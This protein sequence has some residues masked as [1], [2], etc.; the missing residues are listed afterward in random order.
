MP[1]NEEIATSGAVG[2]CACRLASQFLAAIAT[3]FAAFSNPPQL[4]DALLLGLDEPV[5]QCAVRLDFQGRIEGVGVNPE[6]PPLSWEAW[7][8]DGWTEC[9]VSL[10]ETGGFNRAG[11]V[12]IHVP[13]GHSASVIEGDRAGWVRA[14]IIEPA[15]G[16]PPYTA[17]PIVDRLAACTV[18]GTADA[19]HADI[20]A[21][22]VLGDSEGVPGQQLP[23]SKAPILAGS[24]APL[25]ETSSDAGWQEWT[26]VE[27]FAQSTATD[28]HFILDAVSGLVLFGPAVRT[29][30]GTMRQYGAVPPKDTT[31]RISGYATGGG[32]RG[33]V[34]AKAIQTLR[35]SIPFVAGVENRHPADGGVDA[36]TLDEAKARGPILLR[37][38]SRAVTAEDYE[39]IARETAPEIARVR[40]ISAGEADVPAGSVR[41]L[42]VPAAATERG[43]I[44]FENLQPAEEVLARIGARLDE[45]RIVGTGVSVEPPLYRGITVVGR[46]VARTRVSIDRVR[47]DALDMLYQFL[48]PLPGGGPEG[49]GWPFGRPV[50]AGEIFGLLQRVHGVELVED[51]RLFSADPV[52][53]RRGS[54]A[55]RVELAANSLVFSFE[56][57]ILVQEH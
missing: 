51:V 27:H 33:N 18:G 13:A 19:L 28:R 49:D 42:V 32:R 4:D 36:E 50:Q 30:D 40:C 9:E 6:H 26:R 17:S 41:V 55:A 53:G 31:I 46:M 11:S 2:V 44:R 1:P 24:G 8:G 10:D 37:T 16:Q 35:S 34:A 3:A 12:V 15:E 57:Q 38:R 7:T 56:H 29:P 20:V 25:V 52:S 22:E 45:V 39:I 14:R 5:P 48:N 43:R 54:E 21:E 23:L 47:D